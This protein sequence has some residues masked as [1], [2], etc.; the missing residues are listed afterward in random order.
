VLLL[1]KGH[2]TEP[3]YPHFRIYEIASSLTAALRAEIG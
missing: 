1:L 2:M 3:L